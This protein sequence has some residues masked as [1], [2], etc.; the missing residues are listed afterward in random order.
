MTEF[1]TPDML[2]DELRAFNN[3]SSINVVYASEAARHFTPWDVTLCGFIDIRGDRKFYEFK[4][5]L[6]TL[7]HRGHIQQMVAKLH[8]AFDRAAARQD[9]TVKD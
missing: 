3:L 7:Q 6:R 5:D 9:N 1:M 8:E 2:Q 4:L